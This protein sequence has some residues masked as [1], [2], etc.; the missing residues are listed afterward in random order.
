MESYKNWI[1][2]QYIAYL[3]ALKRLE[4]QYSALKTI[5]AYQNI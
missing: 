2:L 3:Q 4:K 5:L 1:Q